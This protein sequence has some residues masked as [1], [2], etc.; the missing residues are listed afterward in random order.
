[1]IQILFWVI[2]IIAASLG[3]VLRSIE[4]MTGNYVFGYDQGLD[5]LAAWSIAFDHKL[6]LIGSAAGGGFAGLPG[7]FHG[8]GYHY[9]L[10][11]I[12]IISRGNPYGAVVAVWL[13]NLIASLGI[14]LVSKRLF[15]VWGAVGSALLLAVSPF[16]I[17]LSRMI[18]APNF[19]VLCILWYVYELT[20]PHASRTPLR[21][22]LFGCSA[23]LLYHFEIPIAAGAILA[24]IA[25]LFFVE[26]KRR[27]VD[28]FVYG[29]GVL[30]GI[31]PMIV[32]D[33]RHGFMTFRGLVSMMLHPIAVTN[34]KGI[35]FVGHMRV[36]LYQVNGV[37]PVVQNLPYWFWAL[38][39]TVIVI[40]IRNTSKDN[41]GVKKLLCII[42]VHLLLFIPYRNPIYGHYLTLFSF[43][44]VFLFAYIFSYG[45]SRFRWATYGAVFFLLLVPSLYRYPMV[46]RTDYADYGGTAKIR[47]KID[48][49]NTV[50][51][52]A[53]EKPFGLFVFTPPVYTYAYDYLLRWYAAKRYGYIPKAE[54]NGQFYL[55]IEKDPSQPWSSDGWKETVIRVGTTTD[56]WTLPSGFILER[57][58][59][60]TI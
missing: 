46:I 6:T 14:I 44:I 16:F 35:D 50:Y 49:I 52:K 5:M 43:A 40:I 37:F 21:I 19:S 4:V 12:A 31:L 45:M 27:F 36:F 58:Q 54:T 7:I 51:E 32:F 23:A 33:I 55:L 15:G 8:P 13:L 3:I 28:M 38:V 30:V 41:E 48:A 39:L 18:W 17:G 34:M 42:G 24:G 22:F 60:P 1:M 59:G 20:R 53:G 47:G 2:A 9:I 57:R 26:K 56:S 10:A 25:A 29:F 11:A